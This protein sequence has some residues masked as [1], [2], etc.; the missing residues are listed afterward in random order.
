MQ[1]STRSRQNMATAYSWDVWP[2]DHGPGV[3]LA[4]FRYR[5]SSVVHGPG[6]H[7]PVIFPTEA[8]ATAFIMKN[9]PGLPRRRRDPGSVSPSPHPNPVTAL[10]EAKA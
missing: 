1:I 7:G 3:M 5:R 10:E 2:L 9:A 6:S 4:L 8:D